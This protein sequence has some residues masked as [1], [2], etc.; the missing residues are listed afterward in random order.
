MTWLWILGVAWPVLASVAAVVIGRYVRL[1][2]AH[3]AG[4][5][6]MPARP[7]RPS[8]TRHGRRQPASWHVGASR[9]CVS[10]A[11]HRPTSGARGGI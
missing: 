11:E 10:P 5:A 4:G 1:A 2:D 8:A 9:P 3:L 7:R 6:E